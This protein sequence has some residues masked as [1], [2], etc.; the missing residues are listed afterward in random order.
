MIR[1]ALSVPGLVALTVFA[2]ASLAQNPA[3]PPKPA[4][5]EVWKPVPRIITPGKTNADPTS[6][7]IVLFDGKNAD[8]WVAAR[9][10]SP[11]RWTVSNGG[12]TVV[13][14]AGDIR[15]KRSFSN[16]QLHIEWR[17]PENITGK[18]QARGNSGVYLATVGDGG[19]ELQVLDSYENTTY[20][21]GQAGSIYKQFPPLVNAMRKPGE[22]Q[23][24]DVVWTAPTFKADGSL[25]TPAYVT[26]LHNGVLVQDHVA[27][28]G[29]TK[30]IGQPEYRAHGP[31]PILLQAHGDPSPP[32]SFR[33]IWLRELPPSQP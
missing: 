7:A 30:Y 25:A 24:Y 26:A 22:W 4:D 21:N 5:T 19:Y 18:D 17:I 29:D 6:D 33:N 27:L 8:E 23:T 13:K 28:R 20:V 31:S 3:T 1:T 32:I 14:S 16:Y 2:S 9:D 12:L 15:T 10:G 11:A